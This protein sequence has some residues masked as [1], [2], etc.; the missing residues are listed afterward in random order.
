MNIPDALRQG[1]VG[2][3]CT[4][5][6]AL[7]GAVVTSSRDNAVQDQQITVIQH[8]EKNLD[9]TLTELSKDVSQLNVNVAVL[10]QRLADGK[11]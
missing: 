2:I 6:L 4:L 3:G 10:N 1:A 11:R 7:G 5:A 8:H 9:D